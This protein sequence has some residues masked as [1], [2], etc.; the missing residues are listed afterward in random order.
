M[1]NGRWERCAG[2]VVE[3]HV[4]ALVAVGEGAIRVAEVVLKERPRLGGKELG[5]LSRGAIQGGRELEDEG[6][7]RV[8][9]RWRQ[10]MA[11]FAFVRD[12]I[13]APFV[14]RNRVT[15]YRT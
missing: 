2:G 8:A 3:A 11:P 14:F 10:I 6:L 13:V 12:P 9:R 7:P 1:I 15:S 5:N 4:G